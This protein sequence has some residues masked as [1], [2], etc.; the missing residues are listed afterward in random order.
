MRSVGVAQKALDLMIERVTDPSRKT[1]GK[2]LSEHGT[3]LADI[4]RAKAEID[5]A[6]F[7]VLSAAA[8]VRA[9]DSI[10]TIETKG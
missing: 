9:K 8:Q 7:L 3:V 2:M 6:R 10:E 4:A 5:A 1:F